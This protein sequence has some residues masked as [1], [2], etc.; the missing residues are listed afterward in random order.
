MS[1][2]VFG[3]RLKGLRT[4]SG[5]TQQDLAKR[6]GVSASTIGMYEQGRREPD[7]KTLSLICSQLGTSTDYLLG[8]TLNN[9]KDSREVDE[10][11][12][13]FTQILASQQGLMF[14]G[15]PISEQDREKIVSAIRVAA[16][17]AIPD[18]KQQ[19]KSGG[20]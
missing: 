18:K 16:A 11:I 19:P 8:L 4:S 10:L 6:L 5:M 2:S 9:K 17:V 1:S 15:E 20:R 14:N 13:E 12:D 3:E 7:N